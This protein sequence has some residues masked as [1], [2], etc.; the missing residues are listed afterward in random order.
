MGMQQYKDGTFGKIKPLKEIFDAVEEDEK[1]LDKTAAIHIGTP[2]ELTKKRLRAE[3]EA[4]YQKAPGTPG[5]E[6]PE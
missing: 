2:E 1:E 4:D 3:C 5:N 6:R